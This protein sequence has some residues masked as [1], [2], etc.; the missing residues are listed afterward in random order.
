MGLLQ[1][2]LCCAAPGI[3]H[4][5]QEDKIENKSE[6]NNSFFLCM[7]IANLL[8]LDGGQRDNKHCLVIS[9]ASSAVNSDIIMHLPLAFISCLFLQIL[10]HGVYEAKLKF[11]PEYKHNSDGVKSARA[12]IP[13]SGLNA[14][15][16]NMFAH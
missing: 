14:G 6:E 7:T 10:L 15:R 5:F 3:I 11:M 16:G 8:K 12:E 2:A 1:F 9:S 13:K 4:D